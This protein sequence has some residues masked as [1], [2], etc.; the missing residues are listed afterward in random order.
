MRI[1]ATRL[2]VVVML[3]T[4][5]IMVM[6]IAGREMPQMHARQRL[7]RNGR[8]AA[9]GQ[10]A[11]QEGLHIR[12]NPVEQISVLY[13]PYV[14]RAQRVIMRGGA[15]RKQD[16]RDCNAILHC[17]SDQLQRFDTGQHADIGL[18]G[19]DGGETG[20]KYDKK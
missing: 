17:S 5:V 10:D 6:I 1:D 16:F 8:L 3:V 11:R 19:S 2:V 20:N 9:P 15:R 12:A 7:D 4:F 13:P 18:G 14:G